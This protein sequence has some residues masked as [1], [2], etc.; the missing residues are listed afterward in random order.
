MQDRILVVD[1]DNAA[2]GLVRDTLT[3]DTGAEVL[4]L[5]NSNIA[6]SFL[7]TERFVVVIFDLKMPEPNGLDL[8]QHARGSSLN[9]A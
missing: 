3:H 2:C 9:Q 7:T 5:T 4:A 8:A 1:D 6:A